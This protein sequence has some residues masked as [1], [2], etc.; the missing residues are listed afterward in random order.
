MLNFDFYCYPKINYMTT[1]VSNPVF[2]QEGELP[3]LPPLWSNGPQLHGGNP[4]GFVPASRGRVYIESKILIFTSD[5]HFTVFSLQPSHNEVPAGHILEVI[6]KDRIDDCT[7]CRSDCR[8][9]LCCG[10]L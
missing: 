7:T 9:S 1:G 8:Y 5:R 2:D 6:N 4:L 10:F 3:L